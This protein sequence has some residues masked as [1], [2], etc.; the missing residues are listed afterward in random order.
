MKLLTTPQRMQKVKIYS[1]V[2][3][4]KREEPKP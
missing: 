1:T 4:V 3:G 2:A